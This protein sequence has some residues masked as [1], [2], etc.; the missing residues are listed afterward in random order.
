M[1]DGFNA[2]AG[3]QTMFKHGSHMF[4]FSNPKVAKLIQVCCSSS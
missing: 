4:G 1:A 3:V 2:E